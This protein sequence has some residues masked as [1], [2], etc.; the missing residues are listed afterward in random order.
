MQETHSAV[1]GHSPES[2]SQSCQPPPDTSPP[3]TTMRSS[4]IFA[5]LVIRAQAEV[6]SSVDDMKS[7]FKLEKQIVTELLNLADKLKS[8]LNRIQR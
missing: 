2:L 6:F 1:S 4:V 3:L 7:V 8:K 5:I